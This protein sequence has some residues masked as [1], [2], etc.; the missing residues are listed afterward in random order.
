MS[1]LQPAKE[2]MTT[3]DQYA[4][5]RSESREERRRKNATLKDTHAT[6]LAD[7]RDAAAVDLTAL[8]DI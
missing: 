5:V 7:D 3:P 6:S 2:S 8:H 1:A 4:T